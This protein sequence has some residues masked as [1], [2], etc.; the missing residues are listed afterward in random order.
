MSAGPG[1]SAKGHPASVPFRVSVVIPT[2]QRSASVERALR[3]LSRQTLPAR[4]YEVIVSIDGSSDGTAEAVARFSAPYAVRALS[5]PKRGRASACNSGIRA[6]SGELLVLLDDDMEPSPELLSAHVRAHEGDRRLGVLGA[7]P[8][9]VA[10]GSPPVVDY[11]ADRFRRHMEKLTKPGHRIGVRDFYTG[12]FSMRRETFFEA[13][14]FDE[15]FQSYGNEDVELAIRLEAAGIR[16]AFSPEALARQH[17]EK[18]FAALARDKMAQGRTSVTCALRHPETVPSLRI[19]TYRQA[20]RK[21]RLL[22]SVLLGASRLFRFVPRWVVGYV[23]WLE[24]RRPAVLPSRYPLALDYFYWLG[25]RSALREAP[26]SVA[27]LVL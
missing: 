12:N 26:G 24:R 6:A 11:I 20:A 4:D 25:V 15:G 19:G 17:Y 9:A 3:A 5:Q 7:V 27:R 14:L 16:L 1:G 13:G 22:R 8:V 10:A 18:D 23:S 21:W 2:Y